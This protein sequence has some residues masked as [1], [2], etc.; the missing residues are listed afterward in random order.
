[1]SDTRTPHASIWPGLNFEAE[2]PLEGRQE[3]EKIAD[4]ERGTYMWDVQHFFTVSYETPDGPVRK[5]WAGK[6]IPKLGVLLR[7]RAE[8]GEVWSI[9]VTGAALTSPRDLWRASLGADTVDWTDAFECFQGWTCPTSGKAR[10]LP[11][12]DLGVVDTDIETGE[13]LETFVLTYEQAQTSGGWAVVKRTLPRRG[14]ENVGRVVANVAERSPEKARNI[15]VHDM[16][17]GD[18]TFDFECFRA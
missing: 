2:Q 14:I 10:E 18:V 8:R 4:L 17:G 5:V 15:A 12:I 13:K 3:R 6:L 1:V 16:S 7:R 9:K 11:V